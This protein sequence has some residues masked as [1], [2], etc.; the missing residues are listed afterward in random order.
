MESLV[1]QTFENFEII[2]IDD[3]STDSSKE[4]LNEF[5]RRDSRIICLDN[6]GNKGMTYSLNK[7]LKAAKG[8]YVARQDADDRSMP[9]RLSLQVAFLDRNPNI[10]LLGA[11]YHVVDEDGAVLRTYRQPA[12]DTQIRWQML[13]HNAFCHS[14]VM[15]RRS[16]LKEIGTLYNNNLPYSQ[17]YALWTKFL[18]KSH[19]AN[20]DCPLV[21]WRK[22]KGSIS[23]TR[24]G[25]QQRIA[26]KISAAQIS[27]LVPQLQISI[28]EIEKLRSWYYSFPDRLGPDEIRLSWKLL[29][30]LRAF[31]LRPE[32]EPRAA[33]GILKDWM[34]RFMGAIPLRAISSPEVFGFLIALFRLD[35]IAALTCMTKTLLRRPK[36]K[37]LDKDLPRE[38]EPHA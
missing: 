19:A 37:S 6:D 25:E 16:L 9:D 34:G 3:G 11:G 38:I 10:G 1:N 28:Q 26:S 4:I 29:Q 22:R 20:L 30:I 35:P 21:A 24:R 32:I 14:S 17:D 7:G 15:F 36:K 18:E 13:F 23:D 2:A 12:T 31:Q 8:E 33:R 5:A 27:R